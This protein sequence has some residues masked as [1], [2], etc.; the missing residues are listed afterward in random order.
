[1]DP[2]IVPGI[3][4][5]SRSW[6]DR[7][8]ERAAQERALMEPEPADGRPR[9]VRLRALREELDVEYEASAREHVAVRAAAQGALL[10]VTGPVDDSSACR[11]GLRR[12]LQRKGRECL[13]HRLDSL[14][15]ERGFEYTRASVRMQATRW[16]S[17]SRSGTISLNA[18]T[19]FLPPELVDHLLLHELCHTV[20]PNHSARFYEL[21]EA[22]SPRTREREAELRAA[23]RYVPQW[24]DER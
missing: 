1:V 5:R 9:V 23:W 17:C 22:H 8:L 14:A 10:R 12:W 4:E 3:V 11:E 19:L 15:A 2:S 18:K 20:H 16:G 13:P 21:L 24:A 6:I 7:R